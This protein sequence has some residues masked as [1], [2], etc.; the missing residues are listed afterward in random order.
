MTH[1]MSD[2]EQSVTD[3]TEQAAQGQ[4][5]NIDAAV[6]NTADQNR[7]AEVSGKSIIIMARSMLVGAHLPQDL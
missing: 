2:Q 6:I 7:T 3:L 4:G 5:I 1:F